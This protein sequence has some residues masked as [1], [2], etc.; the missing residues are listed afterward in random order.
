MTI[1]F[2]SHT[3]RIFGKVVSIL[4]LSQVDSSLLIPQNQTKR[5]Y[6]IYCCSVYFEILSVHLLQQQFAGG[7][8]KMC[9][10]GS[11]NIVLCGGS[12]SSV[13]LMNEAILKA[14]MRI[15][16]KGTAPEEK[17]KKQHWHSITSN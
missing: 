3:F 11:C 4:F 17:T 8:N 2:N 6:H 15:E 9:F 14:E 12:S 5:L 13:A 16:P 7:E 10:F 1:T